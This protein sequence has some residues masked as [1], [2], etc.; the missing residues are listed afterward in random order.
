M[1]WNRV[2]GGATGTVKRLSFGIEFYGIF[3]LKVRSDAIQHTSSN[4]TFPVTAI[5]TLLLPSYAEL[6]EYY[7]NTMAELHYYSSTKHHVHSIVE[8]K[9]K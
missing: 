1:M 4:Y 7:S 2:E 3:F 9:R 5:A 8:K 6:R